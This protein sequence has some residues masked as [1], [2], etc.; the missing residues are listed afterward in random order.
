MCFDGGAL[1]RAETRKLGCI[2]LSNVMRDFKLG[3]PCPS[4]AKVKTWPTPT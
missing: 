1:Q 4:K 2:Q 3:G